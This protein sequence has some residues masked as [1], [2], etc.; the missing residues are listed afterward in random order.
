MFSLDPIDPAKAPVFY[1]GQESDS[2]L[3]WPDRH[4]TIC[5]YT[6][7]AGGFFWMQWPGTAIFRFGTLGDQVE[8]LS[9]GI[10]SE[11]KIIDLFWRSV[12]PIILQARGK[13]A[14][15]AS[16]VR[17]ETG[18]AAF[19]GISGTGKSTL[20]YGLMKRGFELWTDDAL[21]FHFGSQTVN[22]IPLPS[23]IRLLP[24]TLE[25]FADQ[26]SI[27][28]DLLR[29]KHLNEEPL[30]TI[31]LL[32]RQEQRHPSDEIC[33]IQLPP[34]EAFLQILAHAYC[35]SL[36]DKTEKKRVAT[37]YLNLVERVPVLQIQYPS[38]KTRIDELIQ[39]VEA[40]IS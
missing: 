13:E 1:P 9:E 35:F 23:A 24:E 19:C 31:I 25:F 27:K 30:K 3:S 29:P 36:N 21:V 17:T 16:A 14:L 38:D 22:A 6:Y 4:G 18:I 20:A 12:A 34:K 39:H 2:A 33:S 8:Y 5:A 10:Q 32:N 7:R 26:P 40:L 37:D 11:E 28:S 15:H